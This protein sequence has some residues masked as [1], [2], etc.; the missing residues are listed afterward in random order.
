MNNSGDPYARPSDELSEVEKRIIVAA[1]S[2]SGLSVSA[3]ARIVRLTIGVPVLL[4]ANDKSDVLIVSFQ[5]A[6]AS[7]ITGLIGSGPQLFSGSAIRVIASSL[8]TPV[9]QLLLS[10]EKLYFVPQIIN[11]T[12][13]LNVSEVTP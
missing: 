4:S 8:G 3:A 5:A 6:A 12:P 9:Q 2:A 11:G 7:T 1:F 10:K 13:S